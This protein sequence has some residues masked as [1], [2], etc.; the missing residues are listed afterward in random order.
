MDVRIGYCC[1]HFRVEF[2][3]LGAD[4]VLGNL[5][6]M[7][8][9]WE[10]ICSGFF[11]CIAWKSLGYL[12]RNENVVISYGHLLYSVFECTFSICKDALVFEERKVTISL[13]DVGNMVKDMKR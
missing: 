10:M 7:V 3:G 2:R 12:H 11:F 8:G 9:L 5:L 4:H 1:V 13:S 6:E